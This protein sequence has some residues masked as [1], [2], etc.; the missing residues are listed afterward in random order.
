MKIEKPLILF[1]NRNTRQ[2]SLLRNLAS[3]LL[4]VLISSC[5]ATT[6]I[7]PDGAPIDLPTTFSQTGEQQLR[8]LWWREIEDKNLQETI[9]KALAQNQSL[10][11]AVEKLIQ[12]EALARKAG[13]ELSPSLDA[14]GSYRKS[15][16]RKDDATST[17][18]SLLLG[19]AASY[20]IDLWGRLQASEDAALLDARVSAEDLQA[21]SLSIAA[22][23]ANIWY[24]LAA[25]YKQQELLE[26]Q[27][28]LNRVGLELVQMRF[29]AGQI[30]IADLLQQKQ[31]IE[32]KIGEL[33]EQR[34][35][36]RVLENQLAVLQGVA[37]GLLNLQNKP[38]LIALPPLPSTGI[39]AD[40]LTNRP[41]IR[42]RF[43]ALQAADKRVAAAVADRYPRLSL[44]AELNT[45]SASVR[46]LFDNWLASLAANIVAPLLDG[47]SRQAEVDRTKASA[48]EKLYSYGDSLLTAMSEVEDALVQEKEQLQL[49][50]SLEIQLDLATKTV[51]SLRDRYKQGTAD[52]Q[53]ILD[54]VLSQQSLQRSLVTSKQQ[55]IGFRI[56]LYRALGGESP[57]VTAKS[58]N[59]KTNSIVKIN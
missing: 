30:G 3:L 2:Y 42:S 14:E 24:R 34:A 49:I 11:G 28:E 5:A 31:L 21:A 29:N 19:I 52:Y 25:S 32:S 35:T 20:E 58:S 40:L 1:N 50:R 26:Q 18:T 23:V 6:S 39:P 17:S 56:D 45:S 15:R 9:E 38:E 43:L 12:A 8:Q 33:A 13:A 51:R 37:P 54:A 46:D 44:S 10:K 41:D 16:S 36:T 48:R 27:Q 55:L 47:G 57:V 53:R 7:S 59:K 4:L 22:Q